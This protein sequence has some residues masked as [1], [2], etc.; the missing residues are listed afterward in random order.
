MATEFVLMVKAILHIKEITLPFLALLIGPAAGGKTVPIES[1]RGRNHTYY[2]D[3]FNPHAMVSHMVT[4]PPNMKEGEQHM[5]LR[6]KNKLVL[7]PNYSS[8][9]KTRR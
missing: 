3:N 1:L 8:I 7:A 4:L 9:C 2:T 6:I 5:I